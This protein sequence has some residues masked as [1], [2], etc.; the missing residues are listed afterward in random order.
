MEEGIG[1]RNASRTLV[2]GQG[3]QESQERGLHFHGWL[4]YWPS[5][6]TLTLFGVWIG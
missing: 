2:S 3:S 6:L 1:A 5:E 4:F